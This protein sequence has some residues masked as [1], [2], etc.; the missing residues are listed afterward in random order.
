MRVHQR[1]I[2]ICGSTGKISNQFG[3]F[4]RIGSGG[5]SA[6]E[7]RLEAGRGD[8]LHGTRNFARIA[9]RL[10]AFNDDA[11]IGHLTFL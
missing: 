5:H 3:Q 2:Y 7:R 8:Q 1:V 10:A 11:S 9:N 4:L 6:I